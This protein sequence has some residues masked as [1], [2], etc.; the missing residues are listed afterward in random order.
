MTN[1]Y[2]YIPNIIGYMRVIL[3]AYALGNA[4]VCYETFLY[5]YFAS[6]ALDYFDGLFARGFNQCKFHYFISLLSYISIG[7]T[8]G[9]VL[10]MVTD[11]VGT[12]SLLSVLSVIYPKYALYFIGTMGLDIGSHWFQMAGAYMG[13]RS[14]KDASHQN[15]LVRL[16]YGCKPFF[17]YLCVGNEL[18][19]I[20]LYVWHFTTGPM[21]SWPFENAAL[22]A[23]FSSA[24][25]GS[26]FLIELALALVVPGCVLKQVI[27]L[28]QLASAADICVEVDSQSKKQQ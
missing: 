14:H 28:F 25:L 18:C 12:A 17:G 7:S 13:S 24:P 19:F 5:A 22:I 11:R 16:F 4:F 2:F 27:N 3:L 26:V 21:I 8:F 6:F 9:A 10:D 15:L 1:V 23:Q 20:L